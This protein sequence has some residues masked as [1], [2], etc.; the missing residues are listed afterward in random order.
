[1]AFPEDNLRKRKKVL[2]K[3]LLLWT[4][5]SLIIILLGINSIIPII[6]QKRQI[7]SLTKE[8]EE[9]NQKNKVLMEEIKALKTDP[10]RIEDQARQIGMMRPGEKKVKFIPTPKGEN[11]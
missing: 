5:I 11:K 3:K 8:I 2:R 7:A 9:I 1:M 10:T 6:H 4:T